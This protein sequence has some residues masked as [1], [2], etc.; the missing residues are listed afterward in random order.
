MNEHVNIFDIAKEA[1]VSIATVSRVISGSASVRPATREKV[2]SIVQKYNF[3]PNMLATGLSKRKSHTLGMVLPLIDNPFYTKLCIAAQQEAQRMDYSVMLYQMERG[4]LLTQGFMDA[5]IGKRLDGLV[6]SGD[7]TNELSL[8]SAIECIAQI[9]QYMPVVLINAQNIETNS[10]CLCSDLQGSMQMALRHLTRLGHT[11]I[12]ALGGNHNAQVPR[13]RESA[14][15]DEMRRMGFEE[16]IYPATEGDTAADGELCVAKLL[17]SL[18][19]RQPPTALVTFNDLV[20]MGA[21]KQLKKQGYQLPRDMAVVS[22]D[23]Q[24]FAPYTDPPLTTVDL[25]IEDTGRQAISLLTHAKDKPLDAFTQVFEPTLI[26]RES[27]GSALARV[28]LP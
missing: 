24:F 8:P 18:G 23:N 20:A 13:T 1:G 15:L 12:A 7:V 22:C 4:A 11:R 3:K 10:P 28:R 26:V 25:R 27:C 19:G 17:A 21:L 16:W 14:Y 9:K 2:L 5:L 6:F